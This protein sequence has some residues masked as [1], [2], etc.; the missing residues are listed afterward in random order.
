MCNFIG[1]DF[2][3]VW[4]IQRLVILAAINSFTSLP[5]YFLLCQGMDQGRGSFCSSESHQL[6]Q[7]TLSLVS[8]YAFC[9][10][11][12][13]RRQVSVGVAVWRSGSPILEISNSSNCGFGEIL[14]VTSSP[15][16]LSPIQLRDTGNVCIMDLTVSIFSGMFISHDEVFLACRMKIYP[17]SIPFQL[18]A[19]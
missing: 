4:L 3:R 9:Q 6:F 16:F 1:P 19:I 18:N 8:K 13:I 14:A 10:V 15:A 11:R 17:Q 5:Q 7:S 2:Q 12:W